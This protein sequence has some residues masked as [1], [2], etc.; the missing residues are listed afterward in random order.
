MEGALNQIKGVDLP[1]AEKDKI[2]SGNLERI[3]RKG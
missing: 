1:R 2:F 3:L